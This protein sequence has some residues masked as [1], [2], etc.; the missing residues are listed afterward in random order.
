[1]NNISKAHSRPLGI[2]LSRAAAIVA[3]SWRG[4]S[5][6]FLLLLLSQSLLLLR[7]GWVRVCPWWSRSDWRKLQLGSN[8][9]VRCECA[10][11]HLEWRVV[12]WGGS[13]EQGNVVG[14]CAW[15]IELLQRHLRHLTNIAAAVA[16]CP[17]QRPF[18]AC[19][20]RRCLIVGRRRQARRHR[21]ATRNGTLGRWVVRGPRG[22]RITR[23][24]AG[25]SVHAGWT[26]GEGHVRSMHVSMS[27]CRGLQDFSRRNWLSWVRIRE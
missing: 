22:R 23:A 9:L 18:R 15:W 17:L 16:S 12:L 21:G 14:P 26:R 20:S 1:M 4:P 5:L 27:K 25:W 7:H 2:R 8:G 10:G 11:G 19:A 3:G 24:H 6:T 13:R